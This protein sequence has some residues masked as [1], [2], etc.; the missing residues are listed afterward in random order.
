[1]A[2]P[3]D[4]QKELKLAKAGKAGADGKV[5]KVESLQ[6]KL[7]KKEAQ[8]QRWEINAKVGGLGQGCV[9]GVAN[10]VRRAQGGFGVGLAALQFGRVHG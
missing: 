3:Q 5:G 8:L 7:D 10:W 4:L 9:R 6:N 2:H 1:L